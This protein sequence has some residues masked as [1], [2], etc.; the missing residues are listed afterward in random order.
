[1][2]YCPSP[3][4]SLKWFF[5]K[6]C[7]KTRL[8]LE[9]FFRYC[10]GRIGNIFCFPFDENGRQFVDDQNH[11]PKKSIPKSCGIYRSKPQRRRFWRFR[12]GSTIWLTLNCLCFSSSLSISPKKP[13]MYNSSIA[14]WLFSSK[15]TQSLKSYA[16][17][18]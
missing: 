18:A 16:P 12:T 1:M 7:K 10:V 5:Q 4:L 2:S 17:Q 13:R 14:L 6:L 3:I 15:S 9:P 11:P 8:Y